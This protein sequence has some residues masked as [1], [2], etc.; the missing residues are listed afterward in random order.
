MIKKT[1]LYCPD[2]EEPRHV[3]WYDQGDGYTPQ[4]WTFWE[5]TRDQD[6]KLY[7]W[8][9]EDG[10]WTAHAARNRPGF[11]NDGDAVEPELD[12]PEGP[13]MSFYWPLTS[14]FLSGENVRVQA[15][16][17]AGLNTCLVEVDDVYG[18]ALTGGGMDLSWELALSAV[19]L[20]FYP[21]L[22]LSINQG[23]PS[24]TWKYGVGEIGTA[25]A[26][27]IR[28]ALRYRLQVERRSLLRRLEQV[29]DWK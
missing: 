11:L 3:D 22:G 6:G 7:V 25:G 26:R 18:I 17:L 28:A 12:T 14:R 23:G 5:A 16:K 10:A 20:G 27:R 29:K 4:N 24:A 13:M 21:W 2:V 1:D 8:S 15:A 19:R 9:N